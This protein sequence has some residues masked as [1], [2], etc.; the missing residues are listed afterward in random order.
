MRYRY[1]KYALS[2]LITIIT[3]I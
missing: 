1:K 2:L 3:V